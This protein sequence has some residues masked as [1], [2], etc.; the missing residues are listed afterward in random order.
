MF[1]IDS[2]IFL[3]LF[4]VNLFIL[5][6]TSLI[7][8]HKTGMTILATKGNNFVL[9]YESLRTVK[10]TIFVLD[11]IIFMRNSISFIILIT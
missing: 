2:T 5:V 4:N 10:Q 9:M 3:H 8:R 6:I 11:V 7:V 1:Q